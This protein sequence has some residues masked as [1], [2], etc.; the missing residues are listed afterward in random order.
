MSFKQLRSMVSFGKKKKKAKTVKSIADV[1]IAHHKQK[2]GN[3]FSRTLTNLKEKATHIGHHEQGDDIHH[4][5]KEKKHHSLLETLTPG[6]Q[7][8]KAALHIQDS[9]KKKRRRNS[10]YKVASPSPA[11]LR[12]SGD[13]DGPDSKNRPEIKGRYEQALKTNPDDLE[14]LEHLGVFLVGTGDD[15]KSIEILE[16]AINLGS[17][18]ILVLKGL[19][20]AN[21]F[22]WKRDSIDNEKHLVEAYKAYEKCCREMAKTKNVDEKLQADVLFG[23][24]QVYFFYGTY[25]GALKLLSNIMMDL[26]LY[27]KMGETMLL[28]AACLWRLGLYEESIKYWEHIMNDSPD[29]YKARHIVFVI[30]RMYSKLGRQTDASMAYTETF[31]EMRK[32][33]FI[34]FHIQTA[35][36]FVN[37][38]DTWVDMAKL[39]MERG[40]WEQ[41]VDMLLEGSDKARD[42][43]AQFGVED[44]D[45]EKL[46]ILHSCLFKCYRHIGN[47]TKALK[48]LEDAHAAQPYDHE[49]RALLLVHTTDPE[50]REKWRHYFDVE[51]RFSI[52][53]QKVFR[54]NRGRAFAR[55]KRKFED[56]TVLKIQRRFRGNRARR[57]FMKTWKV[58]KARHERQLRKRAAAIVTAQSVLRMCYYRMSYVKSRNA[59][60]TI[61][62]AW[63][64]MAGRLKAMRTRAIKMDLINRNRRRMAIIIQ[65]AFRGYRLRLALH[66]QWAAIDI[67]AAV[68]GFLTRQK[69]LL[70]DIEPAL[71][72]MGKSGFPKGTPGHYRHWMKRLEQSEHLFADRLE[73]RMKI[74]LIQR[75]HPSLS[76]E[77]AFCAMAETAGDIDY[78]IELVDTDPSFADDLYDICASVN[79]SQYIELRPAPVKG[80][81]SALRAR[82]TLSRR[83]MTALQSGSGN[84][85]KKVKDIA[86]EEDEER[87]RFLSEQ[88]RYAEKGSTLSWQSERYTA[89]ESRSRRGQ[90]TKESRSIE[91]QLRAILTPERTRCFQAGSSQKVLEQS[92][93]G[94]FP[95]RRLFPYV[96]WTRNRYEE[97]LLDVATEITGEP[98]KTYSKVGRSRR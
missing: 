52:K 66:K 69:M 85:A 93:D 8:V 15:H 67:Q 91:N 23:L 30:G 17:K 56:E 88:G 48:S 81:M 19:G 70:A 71:A 39:H 45:R 95:T 11:R 44:Y 31:A 57:R 38:P 40:F 6:F 65:S 32:K 47:H 76:A 3:I 35:R 84:T 26:P 77:A 1:S 54:G 96:D 79:V 83:W 51:E 12:R 59:I 33:N 42:I 36:A 16:K 53:M 49:V 24:A 63:R 80:P 61:Q 58:L 22:I 20:D 2:K 72:P 25:E 37:T 34:P 43:D 21:F 14:A 55:R 4:I 13:E 74:G 29:P 78:A 9:E 50:Q 82:R 90:S 7:R 94:T 92:S 86:F 5:H 10:N 60:I 27:D 62:S 73:M 75:A 28:N 46:K 89:P 87:Q 97:R 18:S 64:G 68:R 98:G 41:A